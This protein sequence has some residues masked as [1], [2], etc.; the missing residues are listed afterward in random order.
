[1]NIESKARSQKGRLSR[2]VPAEITD[3]GAV[4]MQDRRGELVF[5]LL[6]PEGAAKSLLP[7]DQRAEWQLEVKAAV[8]AVTPKLQKTGAGLNIPCT[9]VDSRMSLYKS[10]WSRMITEARP[11]NVALCKRQ[12]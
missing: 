5:P 10:T 2:D 7:N 4:L 8:V 1:M 12:R 11:R 3:V 6:D 9:K